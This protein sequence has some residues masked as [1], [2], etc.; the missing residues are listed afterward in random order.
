MSETKSTAYAN[1]YPAHMP[2][3]RITRAQMV[4]GERRL[5]RSLSLQ[6][7]WFQSSNHFP[8]RVSG[9]VMSGT[10]MSGTEVY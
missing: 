4:W 3:K 8:Y 2:N 6:K 10:V 9:T 7:E 5:Y 1:T